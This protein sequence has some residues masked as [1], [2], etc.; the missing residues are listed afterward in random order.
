MRLM[1]RLIVDEGL[2]EEL[3]FLL[4]EENAPNFF[5]GMHDELDEGSDKEDPERALLDEREAR[6]QMLQAVQGALE[7]LAIRRDLERA[8]MQL[9]DERARRQEEKTREDMR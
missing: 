2:G 9:E 6:L 1:E 7:C 8:R 3:D 4:D 5:L